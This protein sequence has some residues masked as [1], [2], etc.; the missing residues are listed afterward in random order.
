[1]D[2]L[3]PYAQHSFVE[4]ATNNSW[5]NMFRFIPD[6]SRVLDVGCSTGNFG[7]A[8]KVHKNCTTVGVDLN[9]A[10]IAEAVTR[11]E[12][13]YVLDITQP[14]AR[15][16]LGTFDVVV[17]GDVIEHLP[18]P[19]AVLS[20]VHSLLNPNGIVVFS[21]PN[22][23]HL[24]VRLDV[25]EG[26][27]AYTEI[28]LLDKTHLHFYDRPEVHSVF[29][30]SDFIIADELSTLVGYPDRWVAERL[31]ALGLAASSQFLSMLRSTDA[32][33]FQF[34]GVAVP[35][36]SRG[37]HRRAPASFIMPHDELQQKTNELIV[38]NDQLREDLLQTRAKIAALRDH[39]LSTVLH[40]I[41][42]R[43][44]V[45]FARGHR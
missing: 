2:G 14:Q 1:M 6:G 4:I 5:S 26:R 36:N 15:A 30:D 41:R 16:V 40:E 13:A 21:I 17:F 9:A 12:A 43:T 3:S 11:L 39:P 38:E 22:M 45:L 28:G 32:E 24:S 7:E 27:F 35:G 31:N 18:D 44:S 8:L 19:R 37:A 34:V 25:L 23:G 10:D 42:R 20:A 29:E 33:I